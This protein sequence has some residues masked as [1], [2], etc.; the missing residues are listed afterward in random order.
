MSSK[1][2]REINELVI[3]ADIERSD[4]EILSFLGL[5]DFPTLSQISELQTA[6][7]N[8]ITLNRTER[9]NRA[10]SELRRH[11]KNENN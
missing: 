7:S 1:L 6:L 11:L 3:E 10:K 4:D 9:L 5:N 8:A 2:L